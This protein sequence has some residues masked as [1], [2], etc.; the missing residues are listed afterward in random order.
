MTSR[1]LHWSRC[2]NGRQRFV[3]LFQPHGSYPQGQ[4]VEQSGVLDQPDRRKDMSIV[5]DHLTVVAPS[6]EAGAAFVEQALGVSPRAGG[7]HA[8]MGTHNLLL[9]L[10]P[11]MYL[12]VIA[13]NPDAPAPPR[14]RWF[15]LDAMAPDAP[16]RLAAWVAGTQDIHAA[17]S[18]SDQALG[19][20]ETMT[21][22]GLSW[23]M[24][25]L[26]D[27]ALPM[28]G[29][30]PALIEWPQGVHPC[31]MLPA[32]GCTLQKLEIHHPDPWLLERSLNALGFASQTIL[33]P[34][35]GAAPALIALIDTPWG[36]RAL[37][38]D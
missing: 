26:R 14:P 12:E 30:L 33:L 29:A 34:A 23:L 36:R 22:D 31:K 2:F 35:Q 37:G 3:S 6:L 13:I 25:V 8:H 5:I 28:G 24:T 15:G 4:W 16:P 20:V 11:A 19:Q 38:A 17:S 18:R 10:G 32:S 7:V 1:G 21:R 9:S 27:G